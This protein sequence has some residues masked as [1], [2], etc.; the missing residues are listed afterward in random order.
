MG[1]N[2]LRMGLTLALMVCA[3]GAASAHRLNAGLTMIEPNA[4]TGE[5]EIIHRL[6]WHDLYLA[7]DFSPEDEDQI[8]EGL[9]PASLEPFAR[10]GFTMTYE[11]GGEIGLQYIGAEREG[12][13]VFIYFVTDP[14]EADRPVIIDNRLLVAEQPKQSNLTNVKLGNDHYVSLEQTPDRRQPGRVRF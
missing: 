11:D 7:L 6:H 8:A 1:S 10:N 9:P 4:R 12:G 5:L 14:P 2:L 13:Y 3:I